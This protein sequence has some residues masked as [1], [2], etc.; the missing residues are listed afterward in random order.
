MAHE[1]PITGLDPEAI[2]YDPVWVKESSQ[3]GH[4]GVALKDMTVSVSA[5]EFQGSIEIQKGDRFHLKNS[6]KYR[7]DFF[8]SCVD[9]AGFVPLNSWSHPEKPL[10]LF[11]IEATSA[12]LSS[13]M[14]ALAAINH[15]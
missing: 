7:D 10:R 14:P 5:P 1:L 9:Q 3:L 11:L 15:L 4:T 6:F 12:A 8:L 2:A 13:S